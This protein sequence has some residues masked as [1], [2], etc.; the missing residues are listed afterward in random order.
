MQ[1][2]TEYNVH[3]TQYDFRWEGGQINEKLTI[4]MRNLGR[5]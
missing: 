3:S 4:G 2:P 1:N 5:G